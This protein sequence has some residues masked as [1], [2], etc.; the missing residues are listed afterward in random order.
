MFQADRVY[1]LIPLLIIHEHVHTALQLANYY[2]VVYKR[3]H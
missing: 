1:F 3:V 2:R